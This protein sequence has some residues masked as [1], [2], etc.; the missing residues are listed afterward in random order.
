MSGFFRILPHVLKSEGGYAD[1]PADRGGPTMHGITQATYDRWREEGG[2]P[3]RPVK[4]IDSDEV[5]AVYYRDYWIAGK[6]D[7]LPWPASAVHFD[8]WVNHNPRAAARVLQAALGVDVDGIIGPK[9]LS[10]ASK[11]NGQHLANEMLW[12]RLDLYDRIV[13]ANPSQAVFFRGWVARIR[14]LREEIA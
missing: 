10:A 8:G 12:E 2:L 11:A 4:H 13:I 9:T 3:K 7:A 14:K 1:H 5:Q 6:C